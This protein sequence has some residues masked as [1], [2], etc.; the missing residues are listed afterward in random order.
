[1]TKIQPS[2]TLWTLITNKI[3]S[4]ATQDYCGYGSLTVQQVTHINHFMSLTLA[5]KFQISNVGIPSP[6]KF[7]PNISR[8]T[9]C[10][11]LRGDIVA[12]SFQSMVE[13]ML[14]RRISMERKYSRNVIRSILFGKDDIQ[15]NRSII[16]LSLAWPDPLRAGTYR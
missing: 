16:C 14:L 15:N 4:P 1:M 6:L 8:H 13:M 9:R 7:K 5:R 3:S 11:R 2:R 12:E 10:K